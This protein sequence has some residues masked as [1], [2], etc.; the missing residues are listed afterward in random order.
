MWTTLEMLRFIIPGGS[1]EI[2][3]IHWIAFFLNQE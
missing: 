2:D 1:A 3:L